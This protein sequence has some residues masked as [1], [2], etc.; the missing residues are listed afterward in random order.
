MNP[1]HDI[2]QALLA[3]AL[4]VDGVRAGRTGAGGPIYET[5]FVEIDDARGRSEAVAAGADLEHFFPSYHVVFY[6]NF[7]GAD[8][9][10]EKE[11]LRLIFW[12][13]RAA[14]YQDRTLGGLVDDVLLA[15]WDADLLSRHN[16]LYWYWAATVRCELEA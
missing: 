7:T 16:E 2:A 3:L 10:A 4:G 6:D 13:F 12:A 15:E 14:L 8:P 1:L 11:R 9:E 5:V